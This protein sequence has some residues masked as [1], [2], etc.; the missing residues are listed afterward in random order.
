MMLLHTYSANITFICP[1]KPKKLWD[2]LYCKWWPRTKPTKYPRYACNL[3]FGILK[4]I[5]VFPRAKESHRV[6]TF[7]GHFLMILRLCSLWLR[8]TGREEK[9]L[10]G[11]YV[12]FYL[13]CVY[14]QQSLKVRERLGQQYLWGGCHSRRLPG[15]STLNKLHSIW[16]L[17]LTQK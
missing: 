7:S 14:C 6:F 15:R 2:L 13:P 3:E 8:N 9:G 16:K 10:Y 11:F 1:G 5:G 4:G 12:I 17:T